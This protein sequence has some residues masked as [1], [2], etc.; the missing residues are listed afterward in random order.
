MSL[1]V[2]P[3]RA[4][5][6]QL[7]DEQ[8]THARQLQGAWRERARVR[9]WREGGRVRLRRER[10]R[11]RSARAERGDQRAAPWPKPE[12]AA[13][14]NQPAGQRQ[15]AR[16]WRGARWLPAWGSAEEHGEQRRAKAR[17]EQ[18]EEVGLHHQAELLLQHRVR[19][20]G[21]HIG[22]GA[23]QRGAARPAGLR[24]RGAGG[25]ARG[26]RRHQQRAHREADA[27][28]RGARRL[29]AMPRGQLFLA[30]VPI[31]IHTPRAFR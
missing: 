6:I 24:A 22:D 23:R 18:R 13:K 8:V 3:R 2:S 14:R 29:S 12:A 30:P 9:A 5:V 25:A 20:L 31:A 10:P 19:V 4:K 21:E 1:G 15:A 26:E 28:I 27:R 11:V 17:G 16:R 7:T